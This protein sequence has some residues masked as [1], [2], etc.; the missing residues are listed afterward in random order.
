MWSAF[1]GPL[2]EQGKDKL[3]PYTNEKG[4]LRAKGFSNF[5]ICLLALCS[6][7]CGGLRKTHSGRPARYTL[8]RRR[9][10]IFFR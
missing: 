3:F 2:L 8:S 4:K 6:K 9:V 5:R 1:A 10:V 7:R